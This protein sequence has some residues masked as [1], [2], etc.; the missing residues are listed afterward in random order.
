[1]LIHFLDLFRKFKNL[2]DA[3]GIDTVRH[4][5]DEFMVLIIDGSSVTD[6]R[7]YLMGILVDEVENISGFRCFR[8]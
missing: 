1:M 6:N 5:S 2:L 4:R 8:L 3:K 7:Y